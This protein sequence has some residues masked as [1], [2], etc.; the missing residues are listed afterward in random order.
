MIRRQTAKTCEGG[1][2]RYHL[3]RSSG[4]SLTEINLIL[5]LNIREKITIFKFKNHCMLLGFKF[6]N[7]RSFADKACFSMLAS[8]ISGPPFNVARF[9]ESKRLKNFAALKSAIICGANGSGKSSF[10]I[11]LCNAVSLIKDSHKFLSGEG[12]P[13]N[14]FKSEA[15][16][17]AETKFEFE[18]IADRVRY[19]YLFSHNAESVGK[20]SLISYPNGRPQEW[21]LRQRETAG[22]YSWRFGKSLK[23]EK[24]AAKLT[25][26]NVLLLSQAAVSYAPKLRK[27]HDWFAKSFQTFTPCEYCKNA[28]IG[29][30]IA[31]ADTAQLI[32]FLKIAYPDIS[33]IEIKK[34]AY[35]APSDVLFHHA[36]LSEPIPC[37][38]EASGVAA[39][40]RLWIAAKRAIDCGGIFIADTP[41]SNLHT[42]LLMEI[43][44]LFNS[45]ENKS[46]AQFIFT[47]QNHAL[48]SQEIFRRDQIWFCEKNGRGES[49][50][51][52]LS[53][54]NVRKD[55]SIRKA[56]VSGLFG[57]I[58][59]LGETN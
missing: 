38:E 3:A 53:K 52:P 47:S 54:F 36:N 20:E 57:A 55:L 7:S 44:K 5:G 32:K 2:C 21:F 13:H 1:V 41:E 30:C 10:L 18:F 31:G 34:N 35:K 26:E 19:K 42:L 40:A 56:Y 12:M 14:P 22:A 16:N 25:V 6:K 43:I 37:A 39:L 9:E 50:I 27:I 59:K 8:K 15:K 51:Y 45:R 49:E 4:L 29:E 46:G 58:P 24:S 11:S 48:L 33:R 23:K 28:D 17:G